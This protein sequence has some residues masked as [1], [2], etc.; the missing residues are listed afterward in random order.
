MPCSPRLGGLDRGV[1]R[2]QVR[3]RREILDRGDDLPDGL[4]LLAQTHHAF[5][6]RLHLGA[7]SLHPRNHVRRGL[8][9]ALRD[10]RRFLRS[11]RDYLGLLARQLWRSEAD[12]LHGCRRLGHG[13]AADALA[14]EAS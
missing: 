6:D 9:P 7:D 5:R 13:A 8:A 11:V 10:L 14:P 2:Q 4:A 12:L 3:L 1:D